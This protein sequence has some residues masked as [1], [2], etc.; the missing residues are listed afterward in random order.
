MDRIQEI[1]G[2]PVL[3][4]NRAS[5]ELCATDQQNY[6]LD[7]QFGSIEQPAQLAS[8]LEKIPGIVAHGLFIGYT[9]AAIVAQDSQVMLIRPGEAP[10]PLTDFMN[11]P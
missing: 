6:I 3:R 2:Q 5:G 4:I 10:K 8:A 9:R 1:G 7:C 11:L